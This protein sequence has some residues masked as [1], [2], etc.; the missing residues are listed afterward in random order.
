[1][2]ETSA[3]ARI[4]YLSMATIA[5]CLSAC[6]GTD[7]SDTSEAAASTTSALRPGTPT[8][9]KP[10]VGYLTMTG[11]TA[12]VVDA[13]YVM[14][15]AACVNYASDARADGFQ[16]KD[17]NGNNYT[18]LA[19]DRAYS[20]TTTT[21]EEDI[22]FARLATPTPVPPATISTSSPQFGQQVTAFGFNNAFAPG[23]L[24]KTYVTY[25]H[26]DFTQFIGNSYDWGGPRFYGAVDGTGA[27]WG[28]NNVFSTYWNQDFIAPAWKY[29]PA[30]LRGVKLFGGSTM[31]M[32]GAGDFATRSTRVGLTLVSG[33]F[34]RDG[35]G[36]LAL[37][38]GFSQ[39]TIPVA[40]GT[41]TGGWTVTNY[42]VADAFAQAAPFHTVVAA[43]FNGDGST[44]LAVVG[45]SSTGGS[46]PVAL[47]NHNGTFTVQTWQAPNLNAF[48]SSSNVRTVSGDFDGD[49]DGDI[50]LF[51]ANGWT[52]AV[53]ATSNRNGTFSVT[54]R[55]LPPG[56]N[57][58]SRALK[59]KVAVGDFDKDGDAD[60]ALTGADGWTTLPVAFSNRDGTF[61]IS[62]QGAP[63]F[64]AW[65]AAGQFGAQIVAGDFD[66]DGDTDL[67][68]LNADSRN[69]KFALAQ[70]GYGI[71]KGI[72]QAARL[73]MSAQVE[74]VTQ[75]RAMPLKAAGRTNLAAVYSSTPNLPVVFLK[76]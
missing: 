4:V 44:D 39:N 53:V 19:V 46:I 34:N 56:F 3:R 55:T 31:T 63:E 48:A 65:A 73:P 29:A 17:V 72:F 36:D 42:V 35:I 24:G 1:M 74:Y 13:K 62:N 68:A 69:I 45:S 76:P 8:N 70:V 71:P 26:A 9:Q 10:A 25:G 15:S 22:A 14:T 52:T 28:I 23:T 60:I 38:G 64:A 21:G 12:T 58:W 50:A 27:I 40:F 67:A 66:G 30:G 2:I 75:G 54:N 49:G 51:G 32:S 11:C 61:S 59:V 5:A 57:D 6:G 16:A 41:S 20:L 43:D 37:P 7:P 33:D 18:W 47:S